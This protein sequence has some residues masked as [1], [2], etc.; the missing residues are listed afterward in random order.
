MTRR[1]YFVCFAALAGALALL[2]CSDD[3]SSSDSDSS[4]TASSGGGGSASNS[5][6]GPGSSVSTGGGGV[7]GS[8]GG[9]TPSGW[10][11]RSV[12]VLNNDADCETWGSVSPLPGEAGHLYGV[13]LTPPSYPFTVDEVVYELYHDEQTCD[14]G[15]AHR[16]ELYTGSETMPPNNPAAPVSITMPAV[17]LANAGTRVV[18]LPISPPIT[19]QAG[20]H[21][22]VAVEMIFADASSITCLATC[23]GTTVFDRDWWSN[24]T[25]PPYNWATLN[26]F[27]L[28]IHA[29]IG[30]NG[31]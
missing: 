3:Q 18:E 23:D 1:S 6:P 17:S 12:P 19:L 24:A 26:S 31:M 13:R 8:G 21:L 22:F 27:D 7:G 15:L 4:T 9:E 29:R 28:N 20:E 16:V 30:A 25:M 14:A 5:G 2:N 11:S 10:V